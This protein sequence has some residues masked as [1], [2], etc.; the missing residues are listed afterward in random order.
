MLY[1]TADKLEIK[2][3][4]KEKKGSIAVYFGYLFPILFFAGFL[5][6]LIALA[7][8]LRP[9]PDMYDYSYY[10]TLW[11]LGQIVVYPV[12][13]LTLVEIIYDFVFY[14]LTEE[15]TLVADQRGI[16]VK[17]LC[18]KQHI[19]WRDLRDYGMSDI[20]YKYAFFQSIRT[21]VFNYRF[22]EC[23]VF[24]VYF[25]T[26][27]C[28]SVPDKGKKRLKG[29]KAW[30]LFKCPLKLPTSI[31]NGKTA[32]EK[33]LDFCEKKTGITPYISPKARNHVYLNNEESRRV[34]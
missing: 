24:T 5:A 17:I 22:R 30:W 8:Y 11:I 1:E 21:G 6:G 29:V 26:Q 27:K 25:S 2:K 28:V 16:T 7:V 9:T 10:N 23:R 34:L 3:S 19:D 32:M 18:F 20:G 15:Y 4:K 31:V 13:V 33:I 14:I 12:A